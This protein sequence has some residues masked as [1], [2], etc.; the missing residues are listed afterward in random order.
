M[1]ARETGEH[2]M[3][4]SKE[5]EALIPTIGLACVARPTFAVEYA[6]ESALQALAVLREP[7]WPVVGD[8]TLLMDAQSA[9]EAA[10]ILKVQ[11]PDLLV[12]LCSTFSDASMTVELAEQVGA[13]VC[14]WALRE[15]GAVGD[16]L[17]LNSLCGVNIASHALQRTG[18]TVHYIYGYP[19][20]KDLLAPLAA[21]A[22]AAITRNRL[23]QSHV[24][25]VG[26]APTGFYGCQFD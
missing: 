12:I 16:R 3:K 7:G 4:K 15:P 8:A 21:F 14:L 24:G 22:R 2:V 19:D 11:A 6:K 1:Y 5:R 18:H 17:W 13:P 9:R 26:Q 23:R 10:Q 25:L 20:E